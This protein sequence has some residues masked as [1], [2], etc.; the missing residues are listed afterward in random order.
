MSNPQFNTTWIQP[1]A[2]ES[3]DDPDHGLIYK[4]I[5]A[6][7]PG[8]KTNIHNICEVPF[9]TVNV[10]L[11]SRV[12]ICGCDGW[13]PFPVGSVDNFST[14]EEIFNS[15]QAKKIQNSII[16][17]E[18]EFCDI[19]YCGI[20]IKERKSPENLINLSITMDTSCNYSCPSCRERLIFINDKKLLEEKINYGKI[21]YNWLKTTDKNV[22]IEFAGGEP[23]ASLA[24]TELID[25]YSVLPN[26]MFMFRTNGSLIKSN[27]KMIDKIANRIKRWEISIDAGSKDVYEKVRRGGKWHQLLENLSYLKTL[28]GIKA[29][30]FVIQSDNIDDMIPFIKLC[31]QFNMGVNFDLVQDWGTWHNFDEHCTH[32]KSNSLYNKFV[33][34]VKLIKTQYPKINVE[35]LEQWID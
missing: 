16:K 29:A 23:F 25:M 32:Y 9:F 8:I 33:E 18:Y 20:Q 31:D 22:L 7:L 10:D 2:P 13:L 27:K 34:N 14:F 1:I 17:K 24:Y 3:F 26:V 30:S 21:I 5:N 4:R 12:F 11:K 35:R 19:R 6:G 28:P 15:P